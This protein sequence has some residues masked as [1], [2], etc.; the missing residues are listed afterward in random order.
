MR[1]YIKFALAI[2]SSKQI[3]Y[4]QLMILQDFNEK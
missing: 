4:Q 1:K 2:K 3:F